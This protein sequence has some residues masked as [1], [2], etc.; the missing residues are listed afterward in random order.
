MRIDMLDGEYKLHLPVFVK[1]SKV[2]RLKLDN[3]VGRKSIVT[4]SECCLLK[5]LWNADFHGLVQCA[6]RM[7]IAR[8]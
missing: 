7:N 2:Q 8:S 1:L 6:Y 5:Q 4:I 3:H